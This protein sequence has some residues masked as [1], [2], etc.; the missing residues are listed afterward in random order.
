MS[1]LRNGNGTFANGNPGGPGRP[2]RTI[3]REYIATLLGACTLN[4]WQAIVE[5]AVEDAKAGDGKARDWL[6]RFVLGTTPL[7][8]SQLAG[9]ELAGHSPDDDV[10]ACRESRLCAREIAEYAGELIAD[11]RPNRK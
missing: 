7:L 10:D 8:P 5:R 3:E 11:L 9:D 1:D 4:D 6:A 2:R